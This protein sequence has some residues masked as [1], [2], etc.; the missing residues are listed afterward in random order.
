[1]VKF[2]S[3]HIQKTGGRSF[4]DTL[5]GVYGK[6]G[7]L[8]VNHGKKHL[9]SKDDLTPEVKVIHG[10]LN[11]FEIVQKFNL[12]NNIP[13]IAWMRNPVERVISHYYFIQ[14]KLYEKMTFFGADSNI[15]KLAD[16]L[17]S[18]PKGLDIGGIKNRFKKNKMKNKFKRELEKLDVDRQTRQYSRRLNSSVLDYARR[19][20]ARNL[21][22]QEFHRNT[23]TNIKK[24]IGQT[25]R[26]QIAELNIADYKLYQDAVK[27]RNKRLNQ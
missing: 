2:I 23:T 21:M 16:R 3:I 25:I 14:R 11:Y 7:V 9:F 4:R 1:M 24:N 26:K 20:N 13:A 12:D 18:E 19:P 22:Y 8:V 15:F 27:L 10:H 6:N 17:F 5:S